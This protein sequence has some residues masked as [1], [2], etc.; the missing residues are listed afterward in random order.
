MGSHVRIKDFKIKKNKFIK[1]K[2][3]TTINNNNNKK[4]RCRRLEKE[5]KTDCKSQV[6]MKENFRE[7]VEVWVF[8]A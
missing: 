2:H 1:K 6:G 7:I 8:A 4:A 5:N 3:R